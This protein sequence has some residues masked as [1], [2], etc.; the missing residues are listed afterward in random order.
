M[1]LY[2]KSIYTLLHQLNDRYPNL[3]FMITEN[4][5]GYRDQLVDGQVHDTYR[6][7]FLKG[8]VNW[9]LK[10]RE[11]GCDVRGYFVWSTMDLYSWINGY[12]KRYGLIY[13]DYNDNYRRIPKD[14]Y[15]WYKDTIAA[16]NL[17]KGR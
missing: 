5:M 3:V 8:F 9:T 12:A 11:E 13:V 10:A 1:E 4:G 16:W 17:K 6:V 15:Y 2:P 7:D 14:S